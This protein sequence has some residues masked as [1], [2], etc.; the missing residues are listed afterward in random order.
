MSG[1]GGQPF[2]GQP[3]QTKPD[4]FW[5]WTGTLTCFWPNAN[6]IRHTASN[7][8]RK[9]PPRIRCALVFIYDSDLESDSF[10]SEKKCREFFSFR[11]RKYGRRADILGG[12]S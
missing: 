1:P 9:T 6:G 8:S 5:F 11:L 2:E 12:P 10:A 3:K 4:G 7:K